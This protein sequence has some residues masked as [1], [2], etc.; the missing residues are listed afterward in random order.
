MPDQ[1]LRSELL[2]QRA[3]S[4]SG[5]SRNCSVYVN[6]LRPLIQED[7]VRRRLGVAGQDGTASAGTN[8]RLDSAREMGSP[9]SGGK[10]TLASQAVKSTVGDTQSQRDSETVAQESSTEHSAVLTDDSNRHHYLGV[11]RETKDTG[12]QAR[13]SDTQSGNTEAGIHGSCDD[14]EDCVTDPLTSGANTLSLKNPLSSVSA[15]EMGRNS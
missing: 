11:H 4:V 1:L 13:S 12:E 2:S 9:L 14:A 3:K 5:Y 7:F 6:N 10:S 15:A 8:T